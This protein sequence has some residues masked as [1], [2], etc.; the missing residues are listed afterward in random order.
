MFC[1]QKG[2]TIKMTDMYDS[3][4]NI[5]PRC[6]LKDTSSDISAKSICRGPIIAY[7]IEWL[8]R[9]SLQESQFLTK[10]ITVWRKKVSV[11]VSQDLSQRCSWYYFN[12]TWSIWPFSTLSCFTNQTELWQMWPN[13]IIFVPKISTTHVG[14]YWLWRKWKF[15]VVKWN[16]SPKAIWEWHS[17]PHNSP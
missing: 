16:T 10:F 3:K 14:Q 7:T 13:A 17:G 11:M 2:R 8:V 9:F 4:V 15:E 5:A 6:T 1:F 12:R